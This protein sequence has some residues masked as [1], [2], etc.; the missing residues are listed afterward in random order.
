MSGSDV[1]YGDDLRLD[2]SRLSDN[3]LEALAQIV[4]KKLREA[5]QQESDRSGSR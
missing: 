2:L 5:M 4:L 3:E 1:N